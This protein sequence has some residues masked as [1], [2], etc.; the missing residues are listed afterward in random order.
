LA[1]SN[2]ASLI[3]FIQAGSGASS[4]TVSTALQRF[5][6]VAQFGTFAQALTAAATGRLRVGSG[7]TVTISANTTIPSTI[8]LVV[9]KGGLISVNTGVTL[10]V[11]G[12][13]TAGDFEVFDGA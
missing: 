3:G 10:T 13:I 9:E 11:E 8:D 2:G 5:K 6:F 4:E 12:H 7:Q 1:A